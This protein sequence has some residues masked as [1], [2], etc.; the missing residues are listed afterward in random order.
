MWT[1]AGSKL[2][3]AALIAG[4]Q[5]V[6]VLAGVWAIG[7]RPGVI[8]FLAAAA[9]LMVAAGAVAAVGLGLAWRIGSV[10]GFHGVMNVVLLPA[11]ALSGALFPPENAAGWM[12][13]L[14]RCNPAMWAHSSVAGLLGLAEPAPAWHTPALAVFAAVAFLA[15]AAS[16]RRSDAR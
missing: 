11:W 6:I 7:P 13:A 14:M 1:I 12:A 3:A 10:S 16:M 15:A 8:A 2:L 4:C 9:V 5:G